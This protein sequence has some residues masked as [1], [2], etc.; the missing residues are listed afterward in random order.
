MDYEKEEIKCGE[1]TA[2]LSAGNQ[3]FFLNCIFCEYTFLQLE[4]FIRHM[5]E[6]HFP[7][8]NN[9]NFKEIDLHP[10]TKTEVIDVSVDQMELEVTLSMFKIF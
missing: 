1:I 9:Q 6:D 2:L 7:K 3:K 4:K 5:Y 10:F 8:I